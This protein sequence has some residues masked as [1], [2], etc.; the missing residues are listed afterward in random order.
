MLKNG[1]IIGI[2]APSG[3][4]DSKLFDK[5]LE[6]IREMGFN[7]SVPK[8]I[9]QTKRYLAGNDSLR[10]E[11][12]TNF[13][14]DKNVKGIMCARGGF[15]A[16]R[17]LDL[18]DW[19]I[20]QNN[21]KLFIGFSDITALLVNLTKLPLMEVIHGPNI[22]SLAKAEQK[23][24]D[25]LYELLTIGSTGVSELRVAT[26]V[27][28]N[29]G[30]SKGK[31]AGGNLATLNHLVGTIYQPEFKDCILF[32][33][34]TGEAP[35]KIDRM[36]TQMKMAGCFKGIKGVVAGSFNDCEN[37]EM[38]QEIIKEIF[39]EYNVPIL[40]GLES[41]HGRINLSLPLGVDVKLTTDKPGVEWDLGIN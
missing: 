32:I 35:Y 23:T 20:I 22:T 1:D 38:V 6:V 17:I 8:D 16:I 15:G 29:K 18:L 24:K 21:P 5:G 34:D 36:L 25:S 26:P 28:I 41:G 12:I 37:L 14:A 33:E 13:F 10:A 27:I 7:P 40:A 31:L 19:E 39:E 4:F 11:V 2:C 9:Y 30:S 3:S